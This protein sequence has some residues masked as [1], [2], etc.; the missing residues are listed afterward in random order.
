MKRVL[1]ILAVLVL[2]ALAFAISGGDQIPPGTYSMTTDDEEKFILVVTFIPGD[3]NADPAI[4]DASLL[5]LQDK[6]GN[7]IDAGFLD[8]GTSEED[9]NRGMYCFSGGHGR[10]SAQ[11]WSA[12]P[13]QGDVVWSHDDPPNPSTEEGGHYTKTE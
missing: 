7:P 9:P 2:A 13:T 3:P 6:D 12:M 4:P 10:M 8:T 11:M 1:S 5:E